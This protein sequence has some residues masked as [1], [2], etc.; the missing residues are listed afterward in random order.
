M[1]LETLIQTHGYWIVFV[2][3]FIEGETVLIL[4]G[5]AA[6][7]GYL[8]LPGVIL[9][10][11]VGS[12][13]CDQI[14]FHLGRRHGPAVLARRPGWKASIQRVDSL[15]VRYD[16]LMII[17][18]RFLYGL[19]T[20]SPFAMGM[21]SA[22]SIGRFAI[23]NAVG[24]AVWA[25]AIGAAG[26]ALGDVVEGFMADAHDAEIVLLVGVLAIAATSWIIRF[27]RRRRPTA[28]DA[29]ESSPPLVR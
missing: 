10:A 29:S 2:G 5:I 22:I 11:F 19:R 25:V 23:L 6:H 28:S 18:F 4:G 9:A 15:L 27:F 24:A 26:Y 7:G 21:S 1:T 12:L 20:V 8:R 14:F 13:L 3:T 16:L 17:G